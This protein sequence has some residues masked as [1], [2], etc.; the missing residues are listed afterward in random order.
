MLISAVLNFQSKAR[1]LEKELDGT[2]ASFK[3]AILYL[4][5]S[6]SSLIDY[7]CSLNPDAAAIIR[8]EKR[9]ILWHAHFSNEERAVWFK[10]PNLL[11]QYQHHGEKVAAYF[12]RLTAKLDYLGQP[13][14]PLPAMVDWPPMPP[15]SCLASV[16]H[17]RGRMKMPRGVLAVDS[18]AGGTLVSTTFY[19]PSFVTT[20]RILDL[21]SAPSL[22]GGGMFVE[23]KHYLEKKDPVELVKDL[24]ARDGLLQANKEA[25]V[26]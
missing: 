9:N 21:G 6:Y 14:P 8:V 5:K 13:V 17:L 16:S 26:L 20:T 25:A 18:G 2:L 1:R 3:S 7:L 10:A 11:A 19:P 22:R 12:T 15:A 24:T 4:M 23:R